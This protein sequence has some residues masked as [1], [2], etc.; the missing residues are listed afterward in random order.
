MT[1]WVTARGELL[2]LLVGR[3]ARLETSCS[4]SVWGAVRLW[5]CIKDDDQLQILCSSSLACVLLL[6][7]TLLSTIPVCAVHFLHTDVRYRTMFFY[8]LA[9]A[10]STFICVPAA[11]VYIAP[12]QSIEAFAS[13]VAHS[14]ICTLL[15]FLQGTT[16]AAGAS[17]S[18]CH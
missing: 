9:R 11:L 3:A 7:P 15:H 4:Y 16:T 2:L 17:L 18:G 8:L 1:A 5:H 12:S 6:C 10:K 13:T 14:F